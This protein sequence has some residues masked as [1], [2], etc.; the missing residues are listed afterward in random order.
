MGK[1]ER[2]EVLSGKAKGVLFG[3]LWNRMCLSFEEQ[4]GYPHPLL[5]HNNHQV[6]HYAQKVAG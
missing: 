4:N 6:S 5:N 3:V 2:D 1:P